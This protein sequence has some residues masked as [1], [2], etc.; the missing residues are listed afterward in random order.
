MSL[1]WLAPLTEVAMLQQT[2]GDRLP[3]RHH[4]GSAVS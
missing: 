4:I 2:D 1:E 3:A